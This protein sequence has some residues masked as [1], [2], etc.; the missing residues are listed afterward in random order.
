MH[1]LWLVSMTLP[2]AAAACG[3]PGASDVSGGWLTGQLTALRDHPTL[4][5]AVVCVDARQQAELCGDWDGVRYHILPS[6]EN[7]PALLKQHR[8]DLVHIWG[9]EYAAAAAMQQAAAA[10]SLPVLIGMQGVMRDCAAHLCDGVPPRYRQ[11]TK[12]DHLLDRL[13][14]GAL[15]DNLQASFDALAQS[16]AALLGQAR[17]ITGR[18]AFDRQAVTDLA[19]QARYFSCNETLRPAF[20]RGPLWQARHFGRA[21]VLLLS[22]GNYP[23]KNLHTVL[24]A[25]PA[26]LQRWPDA[27]LRIAGWPPLDKGPLFQPLIGRFFPYQRYCRELAAQLGVT[28]HIRYTGPLDAAAMRQAYLDADLFLLPSLSENSPNSLGEAMLLGMPC[29]ASCAGGIPTM[30]TNGT[31]GLL[32]GAALDAEGLANAVTTVLS[33][34]D[35]GTALGQAARARALQTHDAAANAEALTGIYQTILQEETR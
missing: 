11:S 27:Q 18:T 20:Y 14:P 28:D 9:T 16:E 35:G 15:L 31:Q 32:Y 33:A 25:L 3:L 34:P 17:Y 8:P 5:L 2:Q 6:A 10:Q 13:I 1:V 4:Q 23:L 12:L 22:Q 29:V 21:P 24:Q 30:L 19:P 26:I 7:F